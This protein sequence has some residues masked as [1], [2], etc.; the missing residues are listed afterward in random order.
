[1][2]FRDLSESRLPL[3]PATSWRALPPVPLAGNNRYPDDR[4]AGQHSTSV[5]YGLYAGTALSRFRSSDLLSPS[6][7]ESKA[8]LGSSIIHPFGRSIINWREVMG[9]RD[10]LIEGDG[11]SSLSDDI[12]TQA[13]DTPVHKSAVLDSSSSPLDVDS[14]SPHSAS[15]PGSSCS[16]WATPPVCS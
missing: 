15:L 1:M 14:L 6:T 8:P 2:A 12:S 5:K 9:D 7:S 16:P 13:V 4:V 3:A 10:P 11:K